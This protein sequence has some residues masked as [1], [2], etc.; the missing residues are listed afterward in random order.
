MSDESRLE[1][2]TQTAVSVRDGVVFRSAKP[3]STTVIAL[4]RH[5]EDVGFPAAPR[6]VGTG[7]DDRGRET[8]GFIKGRSPQPHP[9]S[10]EAL[11]RL[12]TLLRNLH[13]ATASFV[14]PADAAWFERFTRKLSGERTVIGHGDPGPW[15]ILARDGVPVALIDWDQA[16]PVDPLWELA[17]AAW[18][19]AQLHDDDVAELAGLPDAA[20]RARHLRIFIDAYGLTREQR[21]GFVDRMVEIA[22]HSAREEAML[23][24]IR[25]E[26][27]RA[28]D[29][30]GFP[31][32][33]AIAW[34]ARA[35]SWMLRHRTQLED[36]LLTT[37]PPN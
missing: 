30:H 9:W 7:F 25:P 11:A 35:A 20:T 1:G 10:E 31:V 13:E 22:V 2:G 19:N 18:L 28:V 26:T 3:Q 32:L 21:L 4:L 15:N 12:G 8:L 6:V 24:E 17:E 29:E 27:T 34:R 5:L 36:A 33:W 23:T 16:G 14:P 37:A